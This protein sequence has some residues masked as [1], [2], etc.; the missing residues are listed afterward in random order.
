MEVKP[1]DHVV[2]KPSVAL[3]VAGVSAAGFSLLALA[4]VSHGVWLQ[5]VDEAI[6]EAAH[7]FAL[8]HPGWLGAM[9]A[10]TV[11]GSTAVLGPATVFMCAVLVQRR[12][13][14]H[15]LFAAVATLATLILRLILLGVIARP[16]PVDRLAAAGSW[17]FPSGHSTASAT[18][19]VVLA[20]VCRRRWV[21]V[22]AGTWA[23]MVG[24]SRV[25]LVVHW[26][27]DVLG[28]WLFVLTV[29]PVVGVVVDGLYRP[30]NSAVRQSVLRPAGE[31]GTAP[32]GD[33]ADDL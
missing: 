13:R 21:T 3:V 5:R 2:W 6:S 8:G 11:T 20:L 15:A 18:F 17:S 12:M 4:V 32:G 30:V 1:V 27:S 24:V 23:V 10:I 29:V 19:A 28:A 7:D 25:A 26:P 16:R 22:G 33:G 31:P 9:R 14:R